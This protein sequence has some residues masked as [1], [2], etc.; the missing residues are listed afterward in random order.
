MKPVPSIALILS[1]FFLPASGSL[2]E[3]A[4]YSGKKIL[5]INSYHQGYFWSD[6]EQQGAEK[7]LSGTGVD[8]KVVYMDTKN[9]P[10][11]G[12]MKAAGLKIKNI[13]DEFEPDVVISADDNAFKYVI[14]PYFRDADMSVVF[15]GINWDISVYGAPYANTTGMIEVALVAKIYEHLKKFAQGQR[16]GFI[17]FDS[18][19]ERKHGRHCSDYVE[20]GFTYMKF[21][22][23]FSSWKEAFLEYQ[24]TVDMVYLASPTGVKGWDDQKAARFVLENIK[25]PVGSDYDGNMSWVLLGVSKVSQEQGDYAARCA[26]R[27]LEGVRPSEIPVVTNKK[28][29]LALNLKIAE[30]LGVI[31]TPTML[32][33]AT[34]VI[35]RE[36]EL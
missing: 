7:V 8:F 2:A 1:I 35:G 30:K 9:N 18:P 21:V 20:G 33:S 29:I 34:I 3:P 28:G 27:I 5:Y 23:D 32:R 16:I 10:D 13:I 36:Q 19:S 22:S 12:F 25:V 4:D 6:G 31:F 14:M 11:E 15:C 24:D 17:G 26:L